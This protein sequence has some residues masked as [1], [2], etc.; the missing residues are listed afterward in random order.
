MSQWIFL[1]PFFMQGLVLGLDE[2]HFHYRRGLG[3]WERW[4]HPVDTLSVIL[5]IA[6]TCFKPASAPWTDLFVIISAGSCLLITKDEWLHAKEAPPMEHWLHA[7]L[8]TLH[9]WVFV[10]AWFSWGIHPALLRVQLTTL[11]FFLLYQLFW[12]CGLRKG[13]WPAETAQNQQSIL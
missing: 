6:I 8:F 3:L 13:E 7:L 10:S 11:L 1:T 2:F 4:G 9:P 12:W 5:P